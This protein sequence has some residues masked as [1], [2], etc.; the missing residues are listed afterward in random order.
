MLVY[1]LYLSRSF[2]LLIIITLLF[3]GEKISFNLLYI[4]LFFLYLQ[5]RY[6]HFYYA[7]SVFLTYVTHR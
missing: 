4:V 3:S 6:F 1:N 5:Q 2:S 7:L